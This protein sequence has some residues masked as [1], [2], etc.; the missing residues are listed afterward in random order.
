MFKRKKQNHAGY[1]LS[2]AAGGFLAAAGLYALTNTKAIKKKAIDYKEESHDLTNAMMESGDDVLSGLKDVVEAAIPHSEAKKKQQS[3]SLQRLFKK[4][5][6][7]IHFNKES[8]SSSSLCL[9]Y[10]LS[11]KM[12]K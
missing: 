2:G 9:G 8:F 6:I 11:K 5:W 1:M 12:K 10:F 7:T 4:H 3:L